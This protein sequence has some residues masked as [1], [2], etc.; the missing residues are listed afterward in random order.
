MAD[1]EF[2]FDQDED[3]DRHPMAEVD[4]D[5]EPL[6]PDASLDSVLA[7]PPPERHS[8]IER[9]AQEW[10]N[11]KA[12]ARL[13]ITVAHDP[14]LLDELTTAALEHPLERQW[15]IDRGTRYLDA[16]SEPDPAVRLAPELREVMEPLVNRLAV[17]SVPEAGS[18]PRDLLQRLARDEAAHDIAQLEGMITMI[19]SAMLSVPQPRSTGFARRE[20]TDRW[21]NLH[22]EE[23][24]QEIR[25]YSPRE[26]EERA[27]QR[28][29]ATAGGES[30]SETG[31]LTLEELRSW[32]RDKQLRF[33]QQHPDEW[34]SFLSGAPSISGIK[35]RKK[36]ETT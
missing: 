19:E 2:D 25:R 16:D 1:V 14:K 4:T 26:L 34:Q 11:L 6:P 10:I 20:Y 12:G 9:H 18:E 7:L 23:N 15:T 32:P 27:A 29:E 22:V 35:K 13:R 30:Y 24:G 8:W 21:G 31:G 28:A 5:Q 3:K 17:S 36:G 33:R